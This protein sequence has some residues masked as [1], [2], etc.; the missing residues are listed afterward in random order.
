MLI[1]GAIHAAGG[2][3]DAPEWLPLVLER[4][5]G[6]PWS[7]RAWSSEIPRPLDVDSTAQLVAL[8]V[9]TLPANAPAPNLF[10]NW[11]GGVQ[12]TWEYGDLYL[13]VEFSPEQEP[14]WAFV[15]ERQDRSV[16]EDEPL[17]T[18]SN[19]F[20]ARIKAVI[21]AAAS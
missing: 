5:E 1:S 2:D 7:Q 8:I 13:E 18:T 12:A 14:R 15:Y 20:Q 10:P 16:R 17:E 9:R 21:A 19:Q 3:F 11:D 4:L 6:L